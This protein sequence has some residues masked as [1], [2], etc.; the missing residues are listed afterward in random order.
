M[1]CG[2]NGRVTTC[3]PIP[4]KHA[5]TQAALSSPFSAKI[6]LSEAVIQG[7]ELFSAASSQHVLDFIQGSPWHLQGCPSGSP[8]EEAKEVDMAP[9]KTSASLDL[10]GTTRSAG[11]T[12]RLDLANRSKVNPWHVPGEQKIRQECPLVSGHANL[13]IKLHLG[14][15]NNDG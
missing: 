12:L 2:L 15:C 11:Q 7:Q 5:R 1:M 8:C 10:G 4:L 3:G 9:R 13:F 14:S 6:P